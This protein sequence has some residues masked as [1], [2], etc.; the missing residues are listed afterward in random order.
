MC[1]SLSLLSYGINEMKA[2]C[3]CLTPEASF[4]RL[5]CDTD[6]LLSKSMVIQRIRMIIIYLSLGKQLTFNN[7]FIMFIVYQTGSCYCMTMKRLLNT[8]T[9]LCYMHLVSIRDFVAKVLSKLYRDWAQISG[10]DIMTSFHF[11]SACCLSE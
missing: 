10:S 8:K 4:K 1:L 5:C 9:W 11:L 7:H 3:Y 6:D 2:T